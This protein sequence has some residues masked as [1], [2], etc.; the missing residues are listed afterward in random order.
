MG[1]RARVHHSLAPIVP[2]QKQ[3]KKC[4]LPTTICQQ[5]VW[6]IRT[7]VNTCRTKTNTRIQC[8]FSYTRLKRKPAI[9]V[10][11]TDPKTEMC[12]RYCPTASNI[13][14]NPSET[15][16]V[17]NK[18][19]NFEWALSEHGVFGSFFYFLSCSLA[20]GWA[21]ASVSS[22]PS[23]YRCVRW[24]WLYCLYAV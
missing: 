7:F 5:L 21:S 2:I 19:I 23:V 18:G 8:S 10:H 16:V 22:A 14:I 11:Y 15:L 17:N 9:T 1:H 3:Q 12:V 20:F 24:W 4:S 6:P 13:A